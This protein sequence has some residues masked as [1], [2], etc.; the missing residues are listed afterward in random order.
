MILTCRLGRVSSVVSLRRVAM[1]GRE[2]FRL[3]NRRV[4]PYTD[5]MNRL[6][7]SGLFVLALALLGRGETV[8]DREGAVRG[9]K[10]KMAGDER[11]IY[12]DIDKGFAEAKATGKPLLVVL[13]CVPCLACMGMDASVLT[14]SAVAPL[15]DQFVCVRVINANAL[16]LS[17]FQFDY[18]LSF[19]TMFF[20]PDG[21]LLARFGSWRHQKDEQDT[22]LEGYVATLKETLN[23]HAG[24]PGNKSALEGKQGRPVKWATPV[25]MPLLAQKYER[26]LNW[27]GQVVQSCVHCHQIGD[28]MRADFRNRGEMIPTSLIFPMPATETIGIHLDT[29]SA[30]RVVSVDAGSPAGVAGI[31]A[32]DELLGLD[33]Q[34]IVS[35]ADAAW[36]LHHAPESGPLAAIVRRG[37]A[38]QTLTI[39]LP[40]EWRFKSD[41]GR[42]VG[43]WPMRGMATGGLRLEALTA[44]EKSKLGIVSD[45][46]ALKVLS[47]GKYGPHGAARKAGFLPDDILV[48]VEGV[49]GDMSEGEFIGRL[50]QV[51]PKKRSVPTEVLR[52][53]KRVK[54]NLPMQ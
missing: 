24:Y 47:A 48:E 6:L 4:I 50:L 13:R 44:E 26:E 37:G 5:G 32:G 33:G 17:K 8:K 1:V 11:W 20:H 51:Y 41:I 54:L 9:D 23:L 34:R 12:N 19:S 39:E 46:L 15:L 3:A 45:G 16:D 52:K 21:T 22:T 38:N 18:D 28:A 30:G 49:V 42:R 31:Q 27:D 2:R 40:P 14:S 29:E 36:A 25:D 43:T 53:G 10:A 35:L 7:F